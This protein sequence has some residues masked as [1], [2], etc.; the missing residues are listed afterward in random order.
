MKRALSLLM[1]LLLTSAASAEGITEVAPTRETVQLEEGLSVVRLDGEDYFEEFLSG[2]GADSDMDVVT[3]L[4]KKL[5]F[6]QS[7]LTLDTDS[8]GCSALTVSA[9]NG[10]ALFGRNFDW[11]DCE[12]LIVENHPTDGYASIS[13]VNLDFLS[14]AKGLP[15]SAFDL[16]ALYAGL[17]GMNECGLCAAVLYIQGISAADERSD[18]PDLTTTT[19]IRI[20]LNK[21][22]DVDEALV[23]LEQYDFHSSFNM[24]VHFILSDAAGKSTAAE[25]ID[26]ELLITETPVLTNF[27]I[28]DCA[29]HGIGT[30]QSVTRYDM[31]TA[32]LSETPFMDESALL[33]AMQ[34]VDKSH[35]NDGETTEWTMICNKTEKTVTYY[36]RQDYTRGWVIRLGS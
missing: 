35:W 11:Y 23:L 26:G 1:L 4:A 6:G 18:R 32:Q 36:H 7:G 15:S 10:D 30:A 25:Y 19:L 29:M 2:G 8:F 21:A 20:L 33:K 13:T 31:L 22:A 17:D 16:A 24:P 28:A 5:L 3:F 34:S 27:V 12:T 9:P 14:A